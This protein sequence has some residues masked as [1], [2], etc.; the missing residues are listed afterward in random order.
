ML[1]LRQARGEYL[2]NAVTDCMLC[3][4]EHDWTAH[5][6]STKARAVTHLGDS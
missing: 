3:H 5:D 2:V 1:W 4:A 6:A